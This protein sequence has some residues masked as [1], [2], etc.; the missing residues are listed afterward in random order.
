MHLAD[1][2][3][4]K[5]SKFNTPVLKRFRNS[6]LS[7]SGNGLSK[8]GRCEYRATIIAAEK[9]TAGNSGRVGPMTAAL[10][11]A[12]SC[13]RA[14]REEQDRCTAEL[15]LRKTDI[16][17]RGTVFGF[18]LRDMTK[19]AVEAMLLGITVVLHGKRRWHE[20]GEAVCSK[21]LNRDIYLNEQEDGRPLHQTLFTNVFVLGI[22]LHS[23]AAFVSC[24]GGTK[25]PR[26]TAA[27]DRCLAREFHHPNLFHLRSN[28]A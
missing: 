14:F 25:Q 27:Q 11:T 3:K 20:N 22:Q 4:T 2:S 8:K 6:S 7:T 15:R 10:P 9:A 19:A 18:H 28:D 17:L 21:T 23:D 1:R 16:L 24:S 26:P 5:P 12:S 13:M